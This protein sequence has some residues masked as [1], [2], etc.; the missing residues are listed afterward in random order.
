MKYKLKHYIVLVS[1]IFCFFSCGKKHNQSTKEIPSFPVKIAKLQEAELQTVFSVSIK[2][3]D[4]VQILPRI[5]GKIKNVYVHEGEIVKAGQPLFEIDS[6]EAEQQFQNAKAAVVSAEA[7]MNTAKLN[8]ESYEPLMKEGIISDVQ[9]KTIENAYQTAVA[10]FEQSKANL[11]NAQQ[12]K[13]WTKV[14]SPV[15]GSVNNIPYRYG[16][17]VNTGSVLTTIANTKGVYV[18]FSM[19][20]EQLMSFLNQLEGNNQREKINNIPEVTLTL[21]DGSIYP[22]KGKVK[23]IEGSVNL[24]TGATQLRADFPNPEQLLRSGYSGTITIPRVM[25]DVIVIPQSSTYS[26]QNKTFVYKFQ[27]DSMAVS[28]I[29]DVI[30][31][32]NGK[33]YVVTSGMNDGEKYVYSGIVKV[34]DKMKIKE[35]KE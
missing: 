27:G 19:D 8:V 1:F 5:G 33:D 17:L 20:E 10:T 26:L 35:E 18:Y 29:I 32:P 14:T 23:T 2:G 21:R 31:M 25:K 34:S 16:S 11:A 9:Y 28:Q 12:V 7:Q 24:S 30:G 22:Y 4:D 3:E 15:D 13:S 6:P